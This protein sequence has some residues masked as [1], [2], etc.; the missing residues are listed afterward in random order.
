M[1]DLVDLQGNRKSLTQ[2]F[3]SI[4]GLAWAPD[5]NEVWFTAAQ[6]S[7]PRSLRAVNLN[8]KQRI[9]LSSPA[10]LHF[11]DISKDGEVL[12]NS[13]TQRDQ[14]ILAD[15]CGYREWASP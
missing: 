9:S 13:D 3:S 15:A 2:E 11:Q 10:V 4:Q 1:V 8:G 14:Q 7:E 12:I 6:A 5:G